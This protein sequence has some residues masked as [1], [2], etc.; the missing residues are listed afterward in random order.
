MSAGSYAADRTNTFSFKDQLHGLIRTN[1][2]EESAT[3][4][5]L[6]GGCGAVLM[7]RDCFQLKQ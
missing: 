1:L 7:Q 6:S 2:K 3:G 5:K 4:T